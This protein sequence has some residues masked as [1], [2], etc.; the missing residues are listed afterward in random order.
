MTIYKMNFTVE[1]ED[2]AKAIGSGSLP[3]LATPRVIAMAEHTC[4]LSIEEELETGETT[5]GSFIDVKHIKPTRVGVRVTVTSELIQ[6]D[7][8][9]F[10]FV[11]EVFE[12]DTLIA[13]GAHKRVAVNAERF[14]NQL[15]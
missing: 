7:G 9:L 8:K 1:I 15:Q 3:V 11:Y 13:S 6:S 5:V 10:E 12:G 4:M 14:M 2:T